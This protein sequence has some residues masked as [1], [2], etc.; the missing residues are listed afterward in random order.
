MIGE[1]GLFKSTE[2]KDRKLVKMFHDGLKLATE[3]TPFL[4]EQGGKVRQTEISFLK[5]V[6]N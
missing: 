2:G 6:K 1:V 4:Q 3:F 5:I